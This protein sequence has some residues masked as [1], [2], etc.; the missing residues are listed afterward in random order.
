MLAAPRGRSTSSCSSMPARRLRNGCLCPVLPTQSWACS[1]RLHADSRLRTRLGSFIA[2]SNRRTCC[3]P[4]TEMSASPTLAWRVP[5]TQSRRSL[6]PRSCG[7]PAQTNLRR[8]GRA[9]PAR[10]GEARPAYM[11]PEQHDGVALSPAADQFAFC[12]ALLEALSGQRPFSGASM[13]EL[14]R[15]KGRAPAALDALDT[16]LA[17]AIGR[18]LSPNP[19][20]R[21]PSMAELREQLVWRRPAASQPRVGPRRAWPD[22]FT[23]VGGGWALRHHATNRACDQQRGRGSR[24]L[25]RTP[26]GTGRAVD[27]VARARAL[28]SRPGL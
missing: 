27:R 21:W 20:D 28:Q 13:P 12:S 14:R 9:R 16:S 22:G 24:T 19:E 11:A 25:G 2:T 6:R 1:G 8:M 4:R 3:C 5:T 15:A 17:R 23:V 26:A 18:G 10:L 7:P